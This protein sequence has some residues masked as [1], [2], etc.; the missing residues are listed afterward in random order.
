[1]IIINEENKKLY[2]FNDEECETI[3]RVR[4][5]KHIGGVLISFDKITIYNLWTDFP[6]EFTPK[7]IET[8]QKEM[9]YWY[10]FFKSR[11]N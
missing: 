3:Y 9:P 4:D 6:Q 11:L 10:N 5:L 7:Q 1:M 8:I 2:R